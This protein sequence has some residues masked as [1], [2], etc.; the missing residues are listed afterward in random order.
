MYGGVDFAGKNYGDLW[1]IDI[2]VSNVWA[3]VR[4]NNVMVCKS[5]SRFSVVYSKDGVDSLFVLGGEKL[6]GGN[7]GTPKLWELKCLGSKW[8]WQQRGEWGGGGLC[9]MVISYNCLLAL[10]NEIGALDVVANE[11]MIVNKSFRWLGVRT[12]TCQVGENFVVAIENQK[13][14]RLIV[15]PLDEYR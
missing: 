11:K 14:K 4:T 9:P 5:L 12:V 13:L 3:E 8:V 10:G 1:T 2:M 6:G 15:D 7:L